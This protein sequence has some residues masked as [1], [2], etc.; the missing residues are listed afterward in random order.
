MISG[1]KEAASELASEGFVVWT[2]QYFQRLEFRFLNY[3]SCK[4][5]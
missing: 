1:V 4:K 2:Q 3:L 5:M